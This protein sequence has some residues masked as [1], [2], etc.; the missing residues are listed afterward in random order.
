ML[1]A[2]EGAD[3]TFF[4]RDNAAAAADVVKAADARGRA[5][6]TSEQVDVRDVAACAA[7]VERVVERAGASTFSSTTP[8]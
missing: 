6:S 3:V 2:G 4:Y 8:A 5:R 1:L 7:A